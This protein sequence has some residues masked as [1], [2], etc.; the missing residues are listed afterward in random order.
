M[1]NA[2]SEGRIRVGFRDGVHGLD[3]L[4]LL[5]KALGDQRVPDSVVLAKE[6]LSY[7]ADSVKVEWRFPT[8]SLDGGL[9]A[10]IYSTAFTE[11]KP[12]LR[13]GS[14]TKEELVRLGKERLK[15]RLSD[16]EKNYTVKPLPSRE[17]PVGVETAYLLSDPRSIDALV[18]EAINAE[19]IGMNNITPVHFGEFFIDSFFYEKEH[20]DE[21]LGHPV[22]GSLRVRMQGNPTHDIANAAPRLIR[23]ANLVEEV[24]NSVYNS[25]AIPWPMPDKTILLGTRGYATEAVA[26]KAAPTSR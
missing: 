23:F 8:M 19:R 7:P 11:L 9:T 2:H 5:G 14:F 18:A 6:T 24:L 21:V 4:I 26:K 3:N 15:V 16:F 20:A 22:F 1:S 12:K 17:G 13:E 10:T 25:S